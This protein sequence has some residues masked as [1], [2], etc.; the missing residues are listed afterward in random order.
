MN[1]NRLYRRSLVVL[2]VAALAMVL[3]GSRPPI[4]GMALAL[5]SVAPLSVFVPLILVSTT[6][7]QHRCNFF[8]ILAFSVLAVAMVAVSLE[9]SDALSGFVAW[10][11]PAI[12]FVA[13]VFAAGC[14]ALVGRI[15]EGRGE[16]D[17]TIRGSG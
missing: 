11:V 1:A 16:C 17:P 8:A 9:P 13:A 6:A 10:V 3:A 5:W 7:T 15:L 2:A 4:G 14:A 12:L